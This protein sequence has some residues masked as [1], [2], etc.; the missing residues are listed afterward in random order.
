MRGANFDEGQ[1][2][3][4]DSGISFIYLFFVYKPLHI[5]QCL[6]RHQLQV[7]SQMECEEMP[8]TGWIVV[9]LWIDKHNACALSCQYSQQ[10]GATF[11]KRS[12]VRQAPYIVNMPSTGVLLITVYN[13]RT[14]C[15]WATECFPFRTSCL[16]LRWEKRVRSCT[17]T[18]SKIIIL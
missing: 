15:W 6:S 11:N 12:R 8:V 18:C 1:K 13:V 2:Y 9:D 3:D 14:L 16:V 4:V 17:K 5:F 10:T 7:N